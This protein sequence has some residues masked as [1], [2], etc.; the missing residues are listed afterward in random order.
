MT[1]VVPGG[2]APEQAQDRSPEPPPP[3]RAQPRSARTGRDL[4]WMWPV[5][6]VGLGGAAAWWPLAAVGLLA[7]GVVLVLAF[8]APRTTA[9]LVVLAALFLRPLEHLVPVVQAAYPDEALIAL[10]V[11][12]MP[13][14]RL[15]GRR[16]LRTFPGQWWFAGFVVCGLLSSL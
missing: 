4:S 9:G 13:L 8:T 5:A 12:T 2:A 14:R 11:V 3:T 1:A 15:L 10:C 16:P 7:G 6:A